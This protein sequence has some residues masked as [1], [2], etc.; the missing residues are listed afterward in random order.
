MR[1]IFAAKFLIPALFQINKLILLNKEVSNKMKW[2]QTIGLFC[3]FKLKFKCFIEALQ[4]N[5]K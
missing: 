4:G 1:Q 3:I 2:K 5:A